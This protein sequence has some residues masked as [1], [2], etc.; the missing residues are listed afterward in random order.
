MK[1]GNGKHLLRTENKMMF[2][3]T[4][5]NYLSAKYKQKGGYF[6]I[7]LYGKVN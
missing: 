3:T 2:K 5:I 1:I 4:K 6:M 7:I